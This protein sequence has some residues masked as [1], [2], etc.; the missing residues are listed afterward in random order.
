MLRG[1]EP[2]NI[3]TGTAG[4]TWGGLNCCVGRIE[5]DDGKDFYIQVR[6]PCCICLYAALIRV[7]TMVLVMYTHTHTVYIIYIFT[8]SELCTSSL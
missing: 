3:N 4:G 1:L 6:W 7:I 2:G 5:G 8:C